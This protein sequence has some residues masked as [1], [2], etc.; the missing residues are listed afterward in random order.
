[1]IVSSVN[2]FCLDWPKIYSLVKQLDKQEIVRKGENAGNQHF[3]SFSP[4]VFR[5]REE[6][7]LLSNLLSENAYSQIWLIYTELNLCHVTTGFI[8]PEKGIGK[9]SGKRR[10]CW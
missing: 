7:N 3:L 5:F 4:N 1:M 8:D 10:K 9:H 6:S 2:A